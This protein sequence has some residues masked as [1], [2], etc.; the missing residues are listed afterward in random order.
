[1]RIA[2]VW[3]LR[4]GI[5]INRYNFRWLTG[6]WLTRPDMRD[7]WEPALRDNSARYDSYMKR[8][9]DLERAK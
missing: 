3:G 2:E 7:V 6:Q 4:M 9:A 5:A 1:M 8:L